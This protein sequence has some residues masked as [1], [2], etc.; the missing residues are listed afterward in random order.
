[1]STRSYLVPPIPHPDFSLQR[2]AK[3]TLCTDR[4][5]AEQDPDGQEEWNGGYGALEEQPRVAKSRVRANVSIA[6]KFLAEEHLHHLPYVF[7]VQTD[8][9]FG[10][11]DED[12]DGN[13]GRRK[14]NKLGE[15]V[16]GLL[17]SGRPLDQ[18]HL[19][20][21]FGPEEPGDQ[22]QTD[23][24]LD[25]VYLRGKKAANEYFWKGPRDALQAWLIE[26]AD[27]DFT[28]KTIL[29]AV[30]QTIQR[31]KTL[32]V[33]RAPLRGKWTGPD[34]QFE[35]EGSLHTHHNRNRSSPYVIFK[36]YKL[37]EGIPSLVNCQLT[38]TR[39]HR[40]SLDL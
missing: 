23:R 32:K 15:A 4:A 39:Y 5:R 11:S 16:R 22:P 20:P 30:I 3:G 26:N 17:E 28:V 6:N 24:V 7:R 29:D 40:R 21:R 13:E 34:T 33:Q 18:L 14:V 8:C 25:N 36:A 38:R 35:V 37:D 31:Y 19:F 27:F 10:F 9:D 2:C 12:S 1:M